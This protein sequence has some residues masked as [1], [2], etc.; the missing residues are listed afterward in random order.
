MGAVEEDG[1]EQSGLE[2]GWV[3]GYLDWEGVLGK[4]NARSTRA[5]GWL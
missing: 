5:S 1:E 3:S 4:R 2:L